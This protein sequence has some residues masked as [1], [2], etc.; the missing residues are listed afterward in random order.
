MW[1]LVGLLATTACGSP[2]PEGRRVPKGKDAPT[3][4]THVDLPVTD[5]LVRA[6]VALRGLRPSPDDVARVSADPSSLTEIIEGYVEEEAFAETLADMHA[7][8]LMLRADTVPKLRLPQIGP[9]KGVPLGASQPAEQEWPLQLVRH[10]ARNDLPYTEVVT[11]DYTFS[12]EIIATAYG[13]P[14]N[15]IGP[16]EPGGWQKVAWHDGRPGAGLLSETSV[17]RR[18]V[19]NGANFNRL[20]ADVIAD[21]L[22]CDP[23][24]GRD[25]NIV[26]S[27]A[28]SDPE[29]VADAVSNQPECVACHQA[30]DPL[31]GFFWGFK[32]QIAKSSIT[33]AYD[34]DCGEQPV[35]GWQYSGDVADYCYPLKTY[36]PEWEDDWADWD[37]RPPNYYGEPATY[38]DD[39]GAL[40]ADDPRFATC[41]VRRFYSW[42][43]QVHVDDVPFEVVDPLTEAFVDGGWSTRDLALAIVSLPSFRRADEEGLG[44][45]ATRPEQYARTV[46]ELTGYRWL[47]EVDD[48]DCTLCWG[49]VDLARS[50]LH[51]YRTVAG[52]TDDDN[53]LVPTHTTTPMKWLTVTVFAQDAAGHAVSEA[54]AG[55]LSWLDPAI[56]DD[57]EAR[58]QIAALFLRFL[59]AEVDPDG[60]EV[61]ELLAL[62]R[63]AASSDDSDDADDGWTAVLTAL[64]L[65]PRMML[66]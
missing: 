27:I 26:G 41:T 16:M 56:S 53:I 43:A 31:G 57:D 2:E 54:R 47:G 44:L 35:P 37:L 25:V 19:S 62:F 12:N 22:L 32:P 45:L 58:A 40:V 6:S 34:S 59:S 1:A 17:W 50:A 60:P 63:T 5:Q 65:D 51:G 46:M 55:R 9:M 11:A 52:S 42:F 7:Q 48:G 49:E 30:L 14:F 24:G 33:I 10:V 4:H 3:E 28:V 23:I 39:L 20:R 29:E 18:H 13:L 15:P 36:N 64:L 38:L 61:D 21:R 66:H 8:Q